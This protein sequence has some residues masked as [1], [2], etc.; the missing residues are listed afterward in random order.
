ML[1]DMIVF[2]ETGSV[3]LVPVIPGTCTFCLAVLV[4]GVMS[5]ANSCHVVVEKTRASHERQSSFQC[6]V[7]CQEMERKKW[8]K[9]MP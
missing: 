4:P 2:L 1:G 6:P 9:K 7:L 3:H 8:A 5:C